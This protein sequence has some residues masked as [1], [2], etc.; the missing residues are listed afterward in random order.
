MSTYIVLQFQ[1]TCVVFPE[2]LTHD[3]VEN[4]RISSNPGLLCRSFFFWSDKS[5]S[6]R[7]RRRSPPSRCPHSVTRFHSIA[8]PVGPG[9][10][11]H[12]AKGFLNLLNELFNFVQLVFRRRDVEFHGFDK[13]RL[14]YPHRDNYSSNNFTALEGPLC[15]TYS[16]LGISSGWLLVSRSPLPGGGMKVIRPGAAFAGGSLSHG[17]MHLRRIHAFW[18]P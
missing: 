2:W 3:P 1:W 10:I 14:S 11:T 9:N 7:K 8:I 15:F 4:N 18:G 16:S 6:F 13:W 17:N 5:H 12:L